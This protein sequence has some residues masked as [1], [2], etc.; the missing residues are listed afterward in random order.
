M[1][2]AEIQRLEEVISLL[3][4]AVPLRQQ[5]IL[6]LTAALTASIEIMEDF[7][8]KQ[9]FIDEAKQALNHE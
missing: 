6:R 2:E 1:Y 7:G 4:G 5:E 8:V 9:R 3:S